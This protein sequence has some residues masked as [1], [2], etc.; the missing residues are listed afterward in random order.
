MQ[1]FCSL[2]KIGLLFPNISIYICGV[3]IPEIIFIRIENK[4]I[5]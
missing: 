5:A 1:L 3:K 2:D 4:R